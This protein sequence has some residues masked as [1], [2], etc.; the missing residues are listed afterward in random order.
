M[1]SMVSRYHCWVRVGYKRGGQV[2]A[3]VGAMVSMVEGQM[4]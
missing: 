4:G 1:R 3:V 2:G